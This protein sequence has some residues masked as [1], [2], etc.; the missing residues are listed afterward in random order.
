MTFYGSNGASSAYFARQGLFA[1]IGKRSFRHF[2]SSLS[3][4]SQFSLLTLLCS[5]LPITLTTFIV[6]LLG[7][8]PGYDSIPRDSEFSQNPALN[9]ELR[10]QHAVSST[11]HVVF[12][13]VPTAGIYVHNDVRAPYRLQTQPIL[14]YKPPSFDAYTQARIRSIRH[15]QSQDLPWDEEGIIGPNVESRETILQLAKMTN[16]A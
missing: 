3:A 7:I 16:N 2:R 12:A 10:H 11:A 15:G 1:H 9:F 5:M 4:N 14:T 6:N 13:D 8:W